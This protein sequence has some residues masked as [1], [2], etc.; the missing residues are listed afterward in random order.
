MR[1][2]I[3]M[4]MAVLSW[5]GRSFHQAGKTAE[6]AALAI[7]QLKNEEKEQTELLKV[8]SA[9]W[10]SVR[11][12]DARAARRQTLALERTPGQ[13]SGEPHQGRAVISSTETYARAHR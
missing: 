3:T 10:A 12:S 8:R 4:L 13:S 6:A 2:A 11:P 7:S 9:P 1:L 5:C